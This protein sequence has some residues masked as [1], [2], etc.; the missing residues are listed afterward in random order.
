MIKHRGADLNKN[1]KIDANERLKDF[2]GNGKI[3]NLADFK[4]YY[5]NNRVAIEK[6][7]KFFKWATSFD[8]GNLKIDNPIHDLLS[9]ESA[10]RKPQDIQAAYKFL[11]GILALLKPTFRLSKSSILMLAKIQNLY[12]VLEKKGITFG[13]SILAELLTDGIKQKKMDCDISSLAVLGLTY[14]LG[15]KHLY[16]VNAP[17]HFFLR[18]KRGRTKL[19]FDQGV[20]I[21]DSYYIK[22]FGISKKAISRGIFMKNLSRKELLGSFYGNRGAIRK[23]NN[24]YAGAIKDLSTAIRL[25]PKNWRAYGNRGWAKLESKDYKGA[26]RDLTKAIKFHK[27]ADL[28]NV[29]AKAYIKLKKHKKAVQDFTEAIKL[30]IRKKAPKM[31][32][33]FIYYDRGSAK[34]ALKDYTG[35]LKDFTNAIKYY[36]KYAAAYNARSKARLK[37]K[38][39]DR[40][41]HDRYNACSLDPHKYSCK[42]KM[43]IT[44]KPPGITAILNPPLIRKPTCVIKVTP[45]GA[46]GYCPVSSQ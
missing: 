36:P 1:G 35:A 21:S 5:L 17:E 19:N 28:Y 44:P 2:D 39:Y 9:I 45:K 22:K 27:N 6:R 43:V 30:N 42:C 46:V 4:K 13:E 33:A 18:Y 34:F 10:E 25:N 14:Q 37:L 24:N 8:P 26:I 29:R 15:I 41:Y 38:D 11:N 12:R 16:G 7:V 23:Q 20:S 32:I 3:G 40:A 31:K